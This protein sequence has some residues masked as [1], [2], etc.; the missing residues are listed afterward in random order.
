[1][2]LENVQKRQ[3]ALS[4]HQ[5]DQIGRILAKWVIALF[6]TFF[7]KWPKIW[8][9]FFHGK[10]NAIILTKMGWAT[11]W[12]IVFTN[13]SGHTGQHSKVWTNSRFCG[14]GASLAFKS[15]RSI[16]LKF[17]V[18]RCFIFIQIWVYFTKR[19]LKRKRLVNF[20]TMWSI[21]W[22]LGIF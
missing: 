4:E 16:A 21:W 8:S 6:G 2:E 12:A 17:G 15:K 14:E 7:Q 3:A 1:M 11:F 10:S 19:A 9:T 18:A 22:S 20:M 5:G 13:S